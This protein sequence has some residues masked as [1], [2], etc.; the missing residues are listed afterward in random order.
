[1]SA[2]STEYE[3]KVGGSLPPGALSYVPRQ[4]D[5]ELFKALKAGEFCYVFNSRQMGKSSLRVRTM[6][7]LKAENFA[8][9]SI[10][11]S[12]LGTKQVTADQWYKGLVVELNRGF[13]L[14]SKP[15]LIAWRKEQADL[16][17]LQQFSLFIEDII[18][19]QVTSHICIFLEEIDNVKNLNFST[20]DFFVCIRAYHE[21]RKDNLEYNRLTFCFLGVATPSDLLV[22]KQR[23]PFNVGRAIDLM[24]FN[25]AEAKSS[26]IQGMLGKVD[27]AEESLQKILNWTGGQ[28][29]LTQKL[30]KL[31]A[32]KADRK[33]NIEHLVQNYVI[34]NW[35]EQDTPVHLKTIRSRIQSSGKC[36]GRLLGLYQQILH[37]GEIAADE[38]DEQINL[39]LSGLVVKQHGFLRVFN[40]IYES[41]FDKNWVE[42]ELASLR[43]AFYS[44]A[45][46]GWVASSEREE[47]WLL[48]GKALQQ[49]QK[50]S[51]DKSLSDLDHRFL[52]ASREL[53]QKDV[54]KRLEAETEAGQMLAEA[55][56]FLTKANS[57]LQKANQK[58]NRR[59]R[60]GYLI[61][62]VT[63]L[64]SLSVV[65]WAE[66]RVNKAFKLLQLEQIKSLTL[67]ANE[68][69]NLDQ[70]LDALVVALKA[71]SQLKSANFID[72]DTQRQVSF[73]LQQAVYGA[74]EYNQLSGHSSFVESVTFSPNDK[75][76]A[77]ASGDRTVKLWSTDGRLLKTLKKHN[78]TVNSISFSPDG[79]T[80]ASG[81]AGGIIKLWSVD[82]GQE[83]KTWKGHSDIIG[84][85]KFSS[86]GKIIASGSWD[87][88]TK[89]WNT[90][91]RVLKTF[92]FA[93]NDISFSPDGR[94][95]AFAC[96]G[97]DHLIVKLWNIKRQELT[98]IGKHGNHVNSVAFNPDGKTIA[99]ASSDETIKL[100][101]EY[102]KELKTF[103]GHENYVSSVV[104]SPVGNILASTSGDGTIKLWN[105]SGQEIKT[106]RG[107]SEAVNKV[108]FSSDA[109]TIASA[110]SDNTVKLWRLED[111]ELQTFKG[112]SDT[113]NSVS[114]S[115]DGQTIASASDDKILKL[116]N[117]KAGQEVI[118]FRGFK[119]VVSSVS[120]SPDGHTI[121]FGIWDKTVRLWS[122]DGQELT[123]LKEHDHLIHE[124][125]FS[126]DGKTIA[127][128]S[129][130]GS[131]RLWSPSRQELKTLRESNVAFQ[132]ITFS[133]DGKIIA[134]ANQ[135]G[136][137]NLWNWQ[138][139]LLRTL[140]GHN[141]YVTS[142]NFS[143]DGKIIASASHD[144]TIK[145]W[146]LEGQNLRTLKG[147]S[148]GINQIR[149]SPNGRVISS[150]S[151]DKTIKFWS[152]DGQE[153]KT[154]RGHSDAVLSIS[155]SPDGKL[156]A[157]AGEDKTIKLW[158]T[159]TLTEEQLLVRGCNW[160]RYYL[161]NN[162]DI[163]EDDRH[164]CDGIGNLPE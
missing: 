138:G 131:I 110:S 14:L 80:I 66:S 11:I 54:Q 104:F 122:L 88:T 149:F 49:A 111:Q 33:P 77:T 10:D 75:L 99:S 5:Q 42:K 55:Y 85:V 119:K 106:L 44:E 61:L 82:N 2:N 154:L 144:K 121:A 105:L 98:I 123:V 17:A 1:M 36:T 53:E 152:L 73:V 108:V 125:I 146:N 12:K 96:G 137:V 136:T 151:T 6:Q 67:S 128:A 156:I 162:P 52:D 37:L 46:A 58:A 116:W 84:S 48:R 120:F 157:S 34:N 158:N 83:L 62:T 23:T 114:F 7:Q 63:M 153:L 4:A 16:S 97:K 81:D 89:F 86:D 45:L 51:A 145:L 76:I 155:F 135:D 126:P 68:L 38:S 71:A 20:D 70:K 79:K 159:E 117:I 127:S 9:V 3:Y 87:G 113:V 64:A 103:K 47:S 129:G 59:I 43:P 15:N 134:S 147:H 163:K 115:P 29:F 41:I 72:N 93:T 57:V 13:N 30:C 40:R 32:Q 109:K 25:F 140:K 101:S 19:N 95:I 78:S 28:P 69:F 21:Y 35:E 74:K 142:V 94:T 130:D 118:T 141:S 112:H 27:N 132:G 92:Q 150:A 18:V 100:W 60:I 161:K 50:W 65:I 164:I 91:G 39:Q 31:V 143:P 8:C 124:V 107:H 139:Q 133:S 90:N 22:D 24:G 56:Q 102:G 26:L 148:A 160:V